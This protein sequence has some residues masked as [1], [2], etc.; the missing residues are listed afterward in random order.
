MNVIREEIRTGLL[1]IFTVS[2]L[3]LV[4][5]YLGAPG[6]FVP[7]KTFWVYVVN[8]DGLKSGGE[9][10]LA[11]RKIGQIRRLYSPVRQDN[12]PTEAPNVQTLIEIRVAR[13]AQIYKDVTVVISQ[14]GLLGEMNIDFNSG[15]EDAGLA[16]G[17]S[18]FVGVRPPGLSDAVPT[19]LSKLDPAIQQAVETLGSLQKAADNISLLTAKESEVQQTVAK[20]NQFSANLVAI[21]GPEGSIQKTL[22]NLEA[23]TGDHGKLGESLENIKNLTA[24]DS[25]L[26]KALADAEK[27]THRLSENKDIDATLKNLR[28]TSQTL[29]LTLDDLSGKFSTIGTNLE[30]ATDTVKHQPWRLVWP[31]TKKYKEAQPTPVPRAKKPTPAKRTPSKSR[32]RRD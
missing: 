29:Q 8:A 21:S 28:E 16:P 17:F 9:V 15:S 32:T 26:A 14:S 4:L 3:V 2:I 30:Q 10:L 19:I 7:M 5:L 20:L 25:A 23:M 11:G 27:F 12:R 24:P 1:V 18:Y 22:N 13:D 6:V 31:T